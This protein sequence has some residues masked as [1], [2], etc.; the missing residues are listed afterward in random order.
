LIVEF[1]LSELEA[2]AE[3]A[4]HVALDERL[5]GVVVELLVVGEVAEGDLVLLQERLD[6]GVRVL[7]A[8]IGVVE[9][10]SARLA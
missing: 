2:A 8:Q 1:S 9:R 6:L 5:R 7:A 3:P 10:R 4:A